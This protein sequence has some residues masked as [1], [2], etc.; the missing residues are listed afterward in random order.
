MD[1]RVRIAA[2]RI[3]VPCDTKATAP[4]PISKPG[5]QSSA[6]AQHRRSFR[7]VRGY[8][9]HPGA[10]CIKSIVY[11]MWQTVK[12]LLCPSA[13]DNGADVPSAGTRGRRP[14]LKTRAP[15]Q[16]YA[17]LGP[18]VHEDGAMMQD[19]VARDGTVRLCVRGGQD[20]QNRGI[21][22]AGCGRR[23]T[24]S[25]IIFRVPP[26]AILNTC[27]RGPNAFRFDVVEVVGTVDTP[28]PLIRHIENAFPLDRCYRV[29]WGY[30][31]LLDAERWLC[32]I[33]GPKL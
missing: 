18:R 23:P 26:C 27:A 32:H 24:P 1:D 25:G 2:S 4:P 9:G 14:R 8:P 7:P 10:A 28:A 11:P 5:S 33:F 3:R 17:I 19:L 20:P 30:A 31:S 15:A 29:P 21:R 13:T 6:I 16:G 12:R 22:A